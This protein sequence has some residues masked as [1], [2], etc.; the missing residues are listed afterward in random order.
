M[1][2]IVGYSI[3]DTIVVYDR[4]RENIRKSKTPRL[5]DVIN[6]SVNETLSRTILTGGTTLIATIAL[7]V[8][9]GPITFNFALALTVGTVVGTYSSVCVASPVTIWVQAYLA[10]R[11]RAASSA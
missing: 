9:G 10:K 1:L 11:Q 8:W 6:R 3:N 7:L 2:T 5:P 4:I